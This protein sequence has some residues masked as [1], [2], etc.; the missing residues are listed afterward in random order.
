MPVRVMVTEGTAA[1]C[2]QARPLM[3]IPVKYLLADQSNDT[4]E[5]IAVATES[6]MNPVMPRKS[7]RREKRG[8]TGR[9]TSCGTWWKRVS[10][11]SAR[12]GPWSFGPGRFYAIPYKIANL[13]DS[14]LQ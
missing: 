9:C 11:T 8:I 5:I 2:T 6:G 10:W 14:P 1:D 13:F 3:G 4:N 12:F 7:N